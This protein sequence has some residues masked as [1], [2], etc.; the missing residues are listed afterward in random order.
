MSAKRIVLLGLGFLF[1]IN[2]F[3]QKETKEQKA[4]VTSLQLY[5]EKK[6]KELLEFGKATLA[7]GTDFPLLRMRTGY[8]AFVLGN[9]S[10]SLKQYEKV[11]GDDNNNKVALYYAY[12]DNL[13]LNNITAARYYAGKLPEEKKGEEKLMKNKIS[14][15]NLEYSFKAPDIT[16]RG[17]AGYGKLGLNI[18]LGYRLELQQAVGFYNQI[19][20]EPRLIAVANN[21]NIDIAQ[22]EYYA[23]LIFAAN[24]KLAVIGGFH[25]LNTPFNNFKYNNMIGFGGVRYT[26]PFVHLQ[27]LAQVAKIRDSS[28]S[29]LDA[30]LTAYPLGNT[31]FYTI[32]KASLGKDFALTQVAGVKVLKN[33][34]LEGNLT[35]GQYKILFANDALYVYDDIDTKKFRLGG[36]L[37][38]L[39][40]KKLMLTANF[41]YD[42]K[43]RYG[44]TSFYFNQYSTTG[45]LIWNF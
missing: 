42:K 14:S 34:W 26:T 1:C 30:S 16:D 32:S 31:K 12:L 15:L 8:A 23:K 36:S 39:A 24:G 44:S 10:E 29:Q 22:K 17:S 38:F 20:S 11:Y 43:I 35:V 4:D 9:Y 5:N 45:G 21:R 33:M 25:Y 28:Y 27:A 19:I 7:E 2:V 18:Q 37:Y 13:Y 3:A 6:W 40:G 41:N